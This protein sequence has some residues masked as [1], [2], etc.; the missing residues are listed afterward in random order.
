M[1]CALVAWLRPAGTLVWCSLLQLGLALWLPSW[2]PSWLRWCLLLQL[3]F[4]KFL[5][6]P[7]QGW[8]TYDPSNRPPAQ[9]ARICSWVSLRARTTAVAAAGESHVCTQFSDDYSTCI[10]PADQ[11]CIVLGES[12]SACQQCLHGFKCALCVCG[13]A[14]AGVKLCGQVGMAARAGECVSEGGPRYHG[15]LATYWETVYTG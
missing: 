1:T 5:F 11:Q 2:L 14:L 6:E 7:W 15:S 12:L 8:I 4:Y 10:G 3:R 13:R 9:C